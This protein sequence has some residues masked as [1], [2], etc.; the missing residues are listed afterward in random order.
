MMRCT[1]PY[2]RRCSRGSLA[3][4]RGSIVGDGDWRWS[5]IRVY[6]GLLFGDGLKLVGEQVIVGSA[7]E[8]VIHVCC[9]FFVARGI[10]PRGKHARKDSASELRNA[11][12]EYCEMNER[13]Q[14]IWVCYELPRI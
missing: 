14:W 9:L 10:R 13:T 5:R 6:L 2:R 1:G 4:R 11:R 7:P 8:L 12:K 3:R